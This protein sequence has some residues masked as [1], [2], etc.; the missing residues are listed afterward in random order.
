[1]ISP[2]SSSARAA[3]LR[4]ESLR[5][6]PPAS[7]LPQTAAARPAALAA[8]SPA[9]AGP[10]AA[11]PTR[12]FSEVLADADPQAW[13]DRLPAAGRVWSPQ[14]T[15]AAERAGVD[16]QL[17]ASLVWTES[18]FRPDAVSHAGAVGLAQLMPDTARWLGVDPT[19]PVSNLDG[20]ARYLADQLDRFGDVEL[21][22]AAYNAGPSRVEQAGGIPNITET[23]N[24]VD[25]VMSRYGH[26]GGRQ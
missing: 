12:P 23:R 19:D 18:D 10:V 15:A 21:A 2:I 5:P 3:W 17:F 16:P 25:R 9:P 4:I 7:R 6:T 20:G 26:L 13:V 24:Y 22:L 1:M 11:T 8:G 14:I